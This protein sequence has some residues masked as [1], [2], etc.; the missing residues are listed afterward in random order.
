MFLVFVFSNLDALYYCVF[1]FSLVSG[2]LKLFLSKAPSHES[3]TFLTL[4]K[5]FYFLRPS[6]CFSLITFTVHP[7]YQR[8]KTF[9]DS[10]AVIL[11]L[12]SLFVF[13][14]FCLS[15]SRVLF[16]YFCPLW[17]FSVFDRTRKHNFSLVHISL[18]CF[19]CLSAF[20]L[21]LRV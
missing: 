3:L 1:S 20:M 8:Q 18:K 15:S 10:S 4:D 14:I 2:L 16:C 5:V 17:S 21:L 6:Q 7:L 12:V 19:E 11:R 13:S 9:I